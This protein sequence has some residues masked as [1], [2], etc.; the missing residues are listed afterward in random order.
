MTNEL[1]Q[2]MDELVNENAELTLKLYDVETVNGS[3]ESAND[4]L[5]NGLLTVTENLKNA[6][7]EIDRLRM[8]RHRNRDSL[9]AIKRLGR[10]S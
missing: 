9:E 6:H 5:V 1:Y 3:L 10:Q 2:R 7:N 8:V 4:R